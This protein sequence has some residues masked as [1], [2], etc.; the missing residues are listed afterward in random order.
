MGPMRNHTMIVPIGTLTPGLWRR[1]RETAVT[2]AQQGAVIISMQS[3]RRHWWSALND[4]ADTLRAATTPHPIRLTRA[5]PRTRALLRELG[6]EN[7]WF[8]SDA[9]V[10][11]GARILICENRAL[12]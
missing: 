9:E 2:S 8:I 7:A 1:V 10:G 4:L 6:I 3:T 12:D 5:L 11:S